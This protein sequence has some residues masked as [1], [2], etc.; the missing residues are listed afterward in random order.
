ML[1]LYLV[2]DLYRAKDNLDTGLAIVFSHSQQT[3]VKNQRCMMKFGLQAAAR[4]PQ[5]TN[6]GVREAD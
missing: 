3:A 2:L 1:I 5:G 6:G 4:G